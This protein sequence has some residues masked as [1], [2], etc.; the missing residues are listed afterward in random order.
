MPVN[1]TITSFYSFTANTKARA[2]QVNTNFSNFRGH[3]LPT[4]PNTATAINN[5]Y[6]LGSNEYKWRNSYIENMFI[7]YTS[8]GWSMIDSTTAVGAV[9]FKKNGV[10]K[11]AIYDVNGAYTSSAYAGQVAKSPIFTASSSIPNASSQNLSGSTCT[12][13]TVGRPVLLC[14]N[15]TD[16]SASAIIVSAAVP[17]PNIEFHLGFM[18]SATTLPSFFHK[19]VANPGTATGLNLQKYFNFGEFT[20]TDL[21]VAGTYNYSIYYRVISNTTTGHAFTVGPAQLMAFEL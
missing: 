4:D 9:H 18:R 1:A 17:T 2:S 3:I 16:F 10:T 12:L 8:T 20:Y 15:P 19:V 5:T 11:K 13:E 14:I 21:P 7:G 6:D